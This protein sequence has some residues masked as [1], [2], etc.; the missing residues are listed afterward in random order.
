MERRIVIRDDD[1]NRARIYVDGEMVPHVYN[2]TLSHPVGK[3]A[4]LQLD[5]RVPYKSSVKGNAEVGFNFDLPE[6]SDIRFALYRQLKEEFESSM[7]DPNGET[8]VGG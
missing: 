8:N 1:P 4:S 2:Y 6:R 3:G 5:L 7:D